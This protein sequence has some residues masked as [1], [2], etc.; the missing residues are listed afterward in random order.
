MAHLDSRGGEIDS[1]SVWEELPSLAGDVAPGRGESF[2]QVFA[3]NLPEAHKGLSKD[4]CSKETDSLIFKCFPTT[5]A[6]DILLTGYKYRFS[7]P[8]SLGQTP[9]NTN[10]RGW[11]LFPFLLKTPNS[12]HCLK[13]VSNCKVVSKDSEHKAKDASPIQPK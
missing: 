7:L 3:V 8:A 5:Q 1:I 13:R 12:Q 10:G 9:E 11:L 4:Q 6:Y 2:Q